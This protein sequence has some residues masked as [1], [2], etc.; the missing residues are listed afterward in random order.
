MHTCGRRVYVCVAF[1]PLMLP[2]VEVFR[3]EE[4]LTD[5]GVTPSKVASTAQQLRDNDLDDRTLLQKITPDELKVRTMNSLF[6]NI[7]YD[8][9]LLCNCIIDALAS[10]LHTCGIS[11]VDFFG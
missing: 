7:Y 6:T 3:L 4:W 1:I 11:I 8:I 2:D 10:C 5:I 9:V